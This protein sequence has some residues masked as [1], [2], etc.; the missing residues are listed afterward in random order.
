MD[1][2]VSY[3]LPFSRMTEIAL[4]GTNIFDTRHKEF[5]GAPELGRLV[6]LRVRQSL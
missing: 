2:N 5:V 4:A 1:A 3:R 6:Y